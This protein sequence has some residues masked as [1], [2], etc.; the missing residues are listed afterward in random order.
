MPCKEKMNR[1]LWL[2]SLTICLSLHLPVTG[3]PVQTPLST[4]NSF[5]STSPKHPLLS[6]SSSYQ[7][8]VDI[9]DERGIKRIKERPPPMFFVYYSL[10][11]HTTFI[12]NFKQNEFPKRRTVHDTSGRRTIAVFVS[13]TDQQQ[14]SC[15]WCSCCSKPELLL[16]STALVSLSDSASSL[17]ISNNVADL[18]CVALATK[19]TWFNLCSRPMREPP[20]TLTFTI[21]MMTVIMLRRSLTAASKSSK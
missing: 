10:C 6:S 4:Q 9:S 19:L 18:C 13:L 17:V 14:H 1:S 20:A 16:C 8:N 3:S 11:A 12:A 15:Q 2:S 5:S 21:I 7:R